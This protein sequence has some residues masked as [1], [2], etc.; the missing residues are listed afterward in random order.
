MTSLL[1]LRAW[2]VV[3]AA[4]SFN[5]PPA[6]LVD[7]PPDA[8]DI[9]VDAADDLHLL[10]T[11]VSSIGG[12]G[13]EFVELYNPTAQPIDLSRYFLSDTRDYWQ[14]PGHASTPPSATIA[15]LDSDFL[16]KFP[17]GTMLAAGAVIVVA[18]DG[19]DFMASF[20]STP[21][22]T[23]RVEIAGA[24]AMESV[25][26]TPGVETERFS[27]E[28]EMLVVFQWDGESDLVR[29]V[30]IVVCGQAVQD[31]NNL[32]AKQPTDG[33]DADAATSSYAV[34]DLSIDEMVKDVASGESYK[35][36]AREGAFELV[37]G[38][39]GITGHDETSEQQ[40]MT[41]D[42]GSPGVTPGVVPATLR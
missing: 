10:M 7:A 9:D 34:D 17:A 29:D 26:A 23:I 40:M 3:L 13:A 37:T 38:G 35:R 5:P 6:G 31:L 36:V 4:C 33:P 24:M 16:V 41:W 42:A 20:G 22:F 19:P 12:S 14:L 32:I 11:E 21:D 2:P 27:N 8:P 28:G 25:V 15:L 39:N 1:S 18:T 30:D